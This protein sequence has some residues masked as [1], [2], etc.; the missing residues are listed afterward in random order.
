[1][2][3]R[4]GK[5]LVAVGQVLSAVGTAWSPR[6]PGLRRAQRLSLQAA[7]TKCQQAQKHKLKAYCADGLP[8]YFLY[9]RQDQFVCRIPSNA[10]NNN[11]LGSL[12]R[13]KGV[14]LYPLRF[15]AR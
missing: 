8:A 9:F 6:S 12:K 7:S 14:G 2:N 3:L 10:I 15:V 1:M 11:K 5:S 4:E 13:E